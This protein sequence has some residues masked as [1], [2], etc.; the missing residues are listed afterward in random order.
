MKR[1]HRPPHD[2]SVL[3][4]GLWLPAALGMLLFSP[5]ASAGAQPKVIDLQELSSATILITFKGTISTDGFT[6]SL[7]YAQPIPAEDQAQTIVEVGAEGGDSGSFTSK[8]EEDGPGR[9]I[10]LAWEKVEAAAI[11]YEIRVKVLR[12]SF[13][14]YLSLVRP[15]ARRRPRVAAVKAAPRKA[16]AAVPKVRRRKAAP[17]AA[18]HRA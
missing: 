7:V 4:S 15:P 14:E 17:R 3:R 6:Q 9:R 18:A 16:A 5:E 2:R 12:E 8:V 1:P 11:P 10:V 13:K